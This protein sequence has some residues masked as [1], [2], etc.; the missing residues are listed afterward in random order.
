MTT[1]DYGPV[2]KGNIKCYMKHCRAMFIVVFSLK[3]M[4]KRHWLFQGRRRGASQSNEHLVDDVYVWILTWRRHRISSLV[5]LSQ[6]AVALILDTSIIF[7]N[8]F[9]QDDIVV[10]SAELQNDRL[11]S[12][13]QVIALFSTQNSSDHKYVIKKTRGLYLFLRFLAGACPGGCGAS[14]E[15][16]FSA[17]PHDTGQEVPTNGDGAF[18]LNIFVIFDMFKNKLEHVVHLR[19]A[20]FSRSYLLAKSWEVLFG[21]TNWINLTSPFRNWACLRFID[22]VDITFVPKQ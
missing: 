17:T 2:P 14:C 15:D 13:T 22:Q 4:R 5:V 18:N 16:Q 6:Y 8:H 9:T 12:T 20:I 10:A 7:R 3:L 21:P 1:T 19:V 11:L